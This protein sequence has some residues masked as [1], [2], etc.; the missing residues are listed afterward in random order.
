MVENI[1]ADQLITFDIK[2]ATKRELFI[3]SSNTATEKLI[4]YNS[5]FDPHKENFYVD[6]IYEG[7][8]AQMLSR[9]GPAMDVGDLNNDGLDDVF[10]GGATN[11]GGQIYLQS[12]KG[13]MMIQNNFEVLLN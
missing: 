3:R 4:E 6:F 11:Y 7:L 12:S 1:G 8:I 2:D 9:E 10:I 13:E 5:P